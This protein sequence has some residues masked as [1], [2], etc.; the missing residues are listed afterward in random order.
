MSWHFTKY[1]FFSSVCPRKGKDG[2]GPGIDTARRMIRVR[3]ATHIEN[4]RARFPREMKGVVTHTSLSADYP[5]RVF[6]PAKTWVS[7]LSAIETE[8]DYDNFKRAVGEAKLTEDAYKSAL[9][10]VWGVMRTF[11]DR[12]SEAKVLASLRAWR[13]K[14]PMSRK[15]SALAPGEPHEAHAALVDPGAL[16]EDEDV[17]IVSVRLEVG[18]SDAVPVA[19][20]AGVDGHT[21]PAVLAEMVTQGMMGDIELERV[22][23]DR[24]PWSK[25]DLGLH[26]LPV[27]EL[28]YESAT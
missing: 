1:G 17:V 22:R 18:E 9:S 15:G 27:F 3:S 12:L 13:Q 20:A 25:V 16:L 6:L 2:K 28:N 21:D 19:I 14:P 8:V 10:A 24:L 26:A 5:A 4:L 11:Q 7:M 23:L